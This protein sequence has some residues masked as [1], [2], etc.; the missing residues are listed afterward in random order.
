MNRKKHKKKTECFNC[1]T[2]KHTL[3]PIP[4]G[5]LCK[6]CYLKTHKN[7]FMLFMDI[8]NKSETHWAYSK[9]EIKEFKKLN[10]SEIKIAIQTHFVFSQDSYHGL[11]LSDINAVIQSIPKPKMQ[12]LVIFDQRETIGEVLFYE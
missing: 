8:L 5:L 2:F 10:I 3:H 9:E 1:G 4:T 11:F 6:K 7:L 12:D